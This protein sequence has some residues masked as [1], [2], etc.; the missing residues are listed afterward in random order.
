MAN[1]YES[2]LTID[3]I[4]N[5]G[6]YEP[7]NC[8]WATYKEQAYNSRIVKPILYK[9]KEVFL[10]DLSEEYGVDYNL[11]HNRISRGWS[12]EKAISTPAGAAGDGRFK[13][14]VKTSPAA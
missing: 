10:H 2:H 11:V 13:S 3:R 5:N 1:G 4:D 7:G 6:N 8:R 9:D 12:L 14:A